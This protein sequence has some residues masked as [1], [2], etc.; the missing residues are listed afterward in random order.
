M[1]ASIAFNPYVTT[2]AAGSFN[3]SSEGYIQG[4]LLD[5]PVELFKIAGGIVS[6]AETIPMW[7]GIA[8]T[9]DIPNLATGNPADVLGGV[10][11][12][13]TT[14][15]NTTGFTVFNQAHSMLQTPQSPVPQAG[16][17][18]SVN[19]VRL[20][21][22]TRLAVACD[23]GLAAIEGG[24]INQN[25]SWDFNNQLL[26]AYDAATATYAITSMVWANTNGGRITVVMTVPS[27]V[28]AVGDVITISGATN[29]GTGGAG[30]VNKSGWVVDTFTDASNFTLAAPDTTGL[31]YGTIA[32]SPV[33][34]AGIG[35]LPVK[36]LGFNIGN[37]MVA[38]YDPVTGFVNWNRS[39][40][41][42][43]ILI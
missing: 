10:I 36:V 1:S 26:Q 18:N 28:A 42:A 14:V 16:S 29:T 27:L 7:G 17:G 5:N 15:A 41:A 43:I 12:R 22:N 34:D 3:V 39:G 19:I 21:S 25:V 32:G 31:V 35:L 40:S 9:E 33:I 8:I 6:T 37:S 23:P 30:A 20:G 11:A 38:V 13:S 2:N 24:A 4:T